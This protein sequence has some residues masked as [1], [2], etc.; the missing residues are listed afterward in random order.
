[1]KQLSPPILWESA[2]AIKQKNL[3]EHRRR[4]YLAGGRVPWSNGYYD[5]RWQEIQ[6]A[7]SDAAVLDAFRTQRMPKGFGI[8]IDERIAEYPWILSRLAQTDGTLL[9]AG[10]TFNFK[11]ILDHAA[12]AKKEL[13][14]CTYHPE[15]PNFNE[16]RISYLYADLRR[17]PLRDDWFDV[18]V[19]QSTIE[20]IDMDNSIYGYDLPN[21]AMTQKKSYDYLKAIDELVRILKPGGTLL[22]TFPTGKFIN[23]GFFQHI[24]AEM[25]ERLNERLSPRGKVAEEYLLYTSEGWTFATSEACTEIESYNPHTGMGKGTDGAAHCRAICCIQFRKYELEKKN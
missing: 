15:S 10:S 11:E 5:Y 24:D 14:I 20:H 7:I 3:K 18:V 17:L 21:A 25:I 2:K 19:S 4:A 12:V 16:R 1:M 22:L 6:A 13:T 8:G 9:D 23:Y